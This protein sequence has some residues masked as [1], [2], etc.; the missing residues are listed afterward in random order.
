MFLQLDLEK[1]YPSFSPPLSITS[2]IVLL[3]IAVLFLSRFY[4]KSSL[5][6]YSEGDS[7]LKKRWMFDGITLLQEGYH[8][9]CKNSQGAGH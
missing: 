4:E 6:L 8:K 9:V 2:T 1:L 3:F 5:P 7:I